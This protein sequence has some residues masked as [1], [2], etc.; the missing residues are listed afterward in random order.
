MWVSP[1]APTP[2]T[3]LFLFESVIEEGEKRMRQSYAGCHGRNRNRQRQ[4]SVFKRYFSSSF[5]GGTVDGVAPPTKLR[6]NRVAMIFQK[7][8]EADSVDD[9]DLIGIN[10]SSIDECSKDLSTCVFIG[11]FQAGVD[12]FCEVVQARQRIA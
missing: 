9:F 10:N 11:M 8:G 1:S 3:R 4:S 12:R 7:K 2:A 5:S 6:K